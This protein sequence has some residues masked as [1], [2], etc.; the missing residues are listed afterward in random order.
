MRILT[1]NGSLI[2]SLF[3]V[4][5]ADF[6]MR[7]GF[8]MLDE[9]G[10]ITDNFRSKL[11]CPKFYWNIPINIKHGHMFI[12]WYR[13]E[14]IYKNYDLLR[15]HRNFYNPSTNKL[16]ALMKLYSPNQADAVTQELLKTLSEACNTFKIFSTIRTT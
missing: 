4:V 16:M 11:I 8:E 6:P 5:S 12:L 7:T 9:E 15:L 13:R 10:L 2:E 14:T 3:D 1:L